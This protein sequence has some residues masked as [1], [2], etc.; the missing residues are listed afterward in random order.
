MARSQLHYTSSPSQ[1]KKYEGYG[2][3]FYPEG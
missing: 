3:Y 2:A 1:S